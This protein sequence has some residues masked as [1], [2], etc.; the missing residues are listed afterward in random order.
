M[1]KREGRILK[2]PRSSTYGSSSYGS[3]SNIK[4]MFHG[5][6]C[7]VK[8]SKNLYNISGKALGRAQCSYYLKT[9]KVR[10]LSIHN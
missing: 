1:V 10:M 5:F 4:V 9:R 3:C 7:S 8:S 2:I 6:S